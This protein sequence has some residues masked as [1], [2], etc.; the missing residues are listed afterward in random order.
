MRIEL[1][2]LITTSMYS[3]FHNFN[4]FIINGLQNEF[5]F[6]IGTW[7]FLKNFKNFF[8]SNSFIINNLQKTCKKIQKKS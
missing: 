5:E 3:I 2:V 7:N 8:P 4:S 6:F 1:V